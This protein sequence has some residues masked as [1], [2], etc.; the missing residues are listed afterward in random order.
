[1]W[2]ITYAIVDEND[3]G[4]Y[5]KYEWIINDYDATHVYTEMCIGIDLIERAGATS[6]TGTSEP[7]IRAYFSTVSPTDGQKYIR[8]V[9]IETATYCSGLASEHLSQKG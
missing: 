8:R 9:T 2:K 4:T 5:E 1:M 7:Y 3:T 6:L